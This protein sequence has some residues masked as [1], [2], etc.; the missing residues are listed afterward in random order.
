MCTRDTTNI[1]SSAVTKRTGAENIST[2]SCVCVCLSLC[3]SELRRKG[4][5]KIGK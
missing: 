1:I 2:R 5:N 4:E 3:M